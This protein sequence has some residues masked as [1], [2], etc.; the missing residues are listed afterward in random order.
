M[1]DKPFPPEQ[2]IPVVFLTDGIPAGIAGALN[3]DERRDAQQVIQMYQQMAPAYQE[4]VLAQ[5]RSGRVLKQAIMQLFKEWQVL[6]SRR[7]P[8][9]IL[10][11]RASLA[12]TTKP[13]LT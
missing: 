6:Q 7:Q 10:G 12:D 3:P 2:S 8:P 4:R 11:V 5:A 1:A 9:A 13:D